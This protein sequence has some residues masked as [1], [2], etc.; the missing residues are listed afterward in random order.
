VDTSGCIVVEHAVPLQTVKHGQHFVEHDPVAL[1]E[2]VD[3]CIASVVEQ[4]G[5]DTRYVRAAGLATQRSTILCAARATGTPLTPLISWQDR[6]GYQDIAQFEPHADRIR[7]ITGLR[8]TPHYGMAKLR[9]C[10]EHVDAVQA[11]LAAGDLIGAPLSSYLLR[12]LSGDV[13]WRVDSV[14]ASRTLLMD[15]YSANWSAELLE[16]FALPITILPTIQPCRSTFGSLSLGDNAVP[17][18]VA[19]GDQ[20]AALFCAGEPAPGTAFINMGTG[21][22]VQVATGAVPVRDERL[23][24]SIVWQ[25]ADTRQYVLEGTV[26]GAGSAVDYFTSITGTQ[27]EPSSLKLRESLERLDEAPL[28]LNGVGGLGSP[29]WIADFPSRFEGEGGPALQL[30]AVYESIVFLVV[31]NLRRMRQRLD[32]RRLIL[33][34]GLAQFDWLAQS[35]ADL[36][37]LPVLQ[38]SEPE[39]TLMG[40]AQLVSNGQCRVHPGSRR[41]E[42]QKN[43]LLQRRHARW[44]AA[45]EAVPGVLLER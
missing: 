37:G 33:T 10:L 40:L 30:A 44:V 16:L 11:Q 45:M 19:T 24:T 31:R 2:S 34:G 23:L 38:P 12:H 21:A 4:L 36:A 15:M 29:D 35:L 6:R 43:A 9:W 39:A 17:I 3:E 7:E 25:D 41:F 32:V 14:N 20:A 5:D 8:L 28:F 1:L 42:P 22:F 26:N 18:S 27:L 13:E